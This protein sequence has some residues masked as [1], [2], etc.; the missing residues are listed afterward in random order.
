M[1]KK[2]V[3]NAIALCFGA[4]RRVLFSERYM[5]FGMHTIFEEDAVLHTV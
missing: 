1:T 4:I 5:V 3:P 2:V